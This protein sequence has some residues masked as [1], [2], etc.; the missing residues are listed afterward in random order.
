MSTLKDTAF[1]LAAGLIALI[2]YILLTA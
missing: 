2:L 1:G